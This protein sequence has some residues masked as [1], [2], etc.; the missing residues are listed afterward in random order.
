[1]FNPG[2]HSIYDL[3]MEHATDDQTM[4]NKALIK[5]IEEHAQNYSLST[6][7]FPF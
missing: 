7:L 4:N 5:R 3:T 1:M 6:D 2:S